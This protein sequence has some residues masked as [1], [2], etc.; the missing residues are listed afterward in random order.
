MTVSDDDLARQRDAGN[1][2]DRPGRN[3]HDPHRTD[4][5]G[6]GAAGGIVRRFRSGDHETRAALLELCGHLADRGLGESDLG[7]VELVLAEALNNITE[8]AYGPEGGPV[9][10]RL[11]VTGSRIECELRDFGRPMP[12]GDPP[13][14]GLPQIAPPDIVPEGGFGWYIIRCLVE[15]L[16][17]QRVGSHNR[18]LMSLTASEAGSR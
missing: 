17:Y 4:P 16:S 11:Q 13:A 18:L 12:M 15:D 1:R 14:A 3:R 8:H 5:A 9:E 2:G 10:V 7:T 6:P